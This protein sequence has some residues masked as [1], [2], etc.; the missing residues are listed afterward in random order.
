MCPILFS[1]SLG[2]IPIVI[3]A[4]AVMMDV[5]IVVGLVVVAF[6]ARRVGFPLERLIDLTLV[7]VVAGV[8]GA[9]LYYVAGNWDVYAANPIRILDFGEG[10]LVYHGALLAGLLA[11]YAYTRWRRL[12][13]LQVCD[14]MAPALALGESI[15]RIGCLL[16]GCCYGAPTDSILGLYLPNYY[17]EWVVRYPTP[18]IQGLTTLVIFGVLWGLRK[19]KP[20]P[21]FLILLYLVLYS[22]TRFL[23][24]F[25]RDRGP[26]ITTFGVDTAQLMSLLLALVGLAAMV[27]L[28][29]RQRARV[30]PVETTPPDE[31]SV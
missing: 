18:I 25:T 8:V 27:F 10:G 14:L 2:G 31:E 5:A 15:A 7:G 21:G 13:F 1:F 17:G 20:F 11:A 12:A 30:E 4:Y 16:N 22:A 9:R 29:R 19:R 3:S 26:L 24:E 23:I 6:E 28:W